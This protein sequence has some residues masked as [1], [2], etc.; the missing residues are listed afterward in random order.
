MKTAEKVS[1]II[2]LILLFVGLGFLIGGIIAKD[3]IMLG[4]GAIVYLSSSLYIYTAKLGNK[5]DELMKN[6]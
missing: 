6:Q 4:A 2:E 5:I 1:L 3:V